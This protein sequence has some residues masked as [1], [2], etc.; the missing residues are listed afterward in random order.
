MEMPAVQQC[1]ERVTIHTAGGREHLLAYWAGLVTWGST[2]TH[3]SPS[4]YRSSSS[5]L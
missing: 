2:Q 3:S 4:T 5:D 1:A